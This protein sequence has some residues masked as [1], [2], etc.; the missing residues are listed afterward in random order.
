MRLRLR[1]A[2]VDA[3]REGGEELR[4][5]RP[6]YISPI[7]PLYLPHISLYLLYM[8]YAWILLGQVNL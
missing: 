5:G 7:S 3:L 6:S 4:R 1:R 2:Q 8:K